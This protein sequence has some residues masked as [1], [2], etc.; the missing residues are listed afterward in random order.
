ME[1]NRNQFFMTGV[2]ILLLGIQFR[3]VDTITL[4]EKTTKFLASRSSSNATSGLAA[5]L[6]ASTMPRKTLRPPTWLGWS[7]ISIGSVCV[8]HALGMKKPGG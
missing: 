2:F 6:P 4:N 7:L 3:L 5:I 1:F 8:L